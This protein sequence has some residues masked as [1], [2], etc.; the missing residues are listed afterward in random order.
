M[1]TVRPFEDEVI[2]RL[3]RIETKLE[4]VSDHEKRIRVLEASRWKSIGAATVLSSAF[5]MIVEGIFI[6]M[7]G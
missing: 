5:T 1:N 4:T 6:H 7:K 3:A 2:D